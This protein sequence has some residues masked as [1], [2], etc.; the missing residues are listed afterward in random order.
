MSSLR[1]CLHVKFNFEQGTLR[2]FVYERYL[3]LQSIHWGQRVMERGLKY[4]TVNHIYFASV[5]HSK[6]KERVFSKSA[7]FHK[8]G[9]L[10]IQLSCI[11]HACVRLYVELAEHAWHLCASVLADLHVN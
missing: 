4:R 3:V 11:Q 10:S 2:S 9:L 6:T 1:A 7:S 5:K 8:G